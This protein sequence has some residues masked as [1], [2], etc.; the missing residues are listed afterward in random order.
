MRFFSG[1]SSGIFEDFSSNFLAIFWPYSLHIPF[2]KGEG[3]VIVIE[4]VV[5]T[6][7][8][9]GREDI[10]PVPQLS[11]SVSLLFCF[12]ALPIRLA[13]WHLYLLRIYIWFMG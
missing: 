5:A 7:E 9:V 4:L 10:R 2:S 12:V 13:R 3:T 8:A 1:F 11:V 6:H